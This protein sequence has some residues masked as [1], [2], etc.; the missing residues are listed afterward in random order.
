LD[1][2]A[3]SLDSPLVGR[4]DELALLGAELALA[5]TERTCRTITL[6]GEP[7]VGKSRLAAELIAS[8]DGAVA[9]LEGRCLP[10]GEGSCTGPSSRSCAGST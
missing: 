6:V 10:Y 5:R 7:G 3:R 1:A 4:S 2:P 9:V 8:I